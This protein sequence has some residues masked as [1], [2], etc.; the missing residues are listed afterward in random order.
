MKVYWFVFILL[1]L[2]T[3]TGPGGASAEDDFLTL[4]DFSV[5]S[6]SEGRYELTDGL[7][8]VLTLVPRDEDLPK[9]LALDEVVRIPVENV[10]VY[11]GRDASLIQ[12][13]GAVKSISGITGTP[14]DWVIPHIREGLASGRV[15]HLGPITSIDLERLIKLKPELVLT[16]DES[17]IPKLSELGIPALI[18]YGAT[19][20]NLNT[21][22]NFV[23]FLAPLFGQREK[24]DEFAT[25]V[26]KVLREVTAK[27]AGAER[28]PKVIWGD[29]YEK[30]VLVEPGHSWAAQLVT[31]VGGDYLFEDIAGSS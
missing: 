4:G 29:I 25:R 16:W 15:V 28:R 17:L 19:A 8:R 10:V 22:L 24:A 14:E 26:K 18:T 2:H 31:A 11:S 3:L 1:T 21:H 23:R 12:V 20:P 5:R 9:G 27:T 13:L 6:L 7:G 30:R